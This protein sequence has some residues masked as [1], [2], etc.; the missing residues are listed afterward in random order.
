MKRNKGI[1]RVKE[2]TVL[3]EMEL[4]SVTQIH[5]VILD[6][7]GTLADSNDAHVHAW[8]EAMAEYGYTVALL[9]QG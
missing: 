8:V 1:I 2:E 9:V 5:G 4:K 6:V 3:Y 7:D